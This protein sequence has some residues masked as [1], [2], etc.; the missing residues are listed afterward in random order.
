MSAAQARPASLLRRLGAML[1]DA[2]LVLAIWMLTTYVAVL[3]FTDRPDIPAGAE[4]ISLENMQTLDS[5]WFSS[6]LFLEAFA[7]F[8]FFWLRHGR[9]LGMQ[10]W[11]LR[12]QRRDGGPITA[13]QALQRFA[14]AIPSLALLGLG[15]LWMLVDRE[16]LAWPDHASGT[17]VVFVDGA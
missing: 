1:Y 14:V 12:L 15:Y 11:R 3:L 10:A 9:T 2:L 5:P 4:R 13:R 8:A 16:R 7:F 6:L 17:R